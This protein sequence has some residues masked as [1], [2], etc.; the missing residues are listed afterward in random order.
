MSEVQLL[1]NRNFHSGL[2]DWS[3][4][5]SVTIEAVKEDAFK[6]CIKLGS[7]VG[8]IHQRQRLGG[9]QVVSAVLSTKTSSG[10]SAKVR[11]TFYDDNDVLLKSE[12]VNPVNHAS[13]TDSTIYTQSPVFTSYAVLS[14]EN[15]IDDYNEVYIASAS[16]TIIASDPHSP[17][18]NM[19][20]Y[21]FP[22]WEGDIVYGETVLMYETSEAIT[23]KLLYI[24]TVMI[25]VTD[26]SLTTIYSQ[27]TDY[28]IIGNTITLTANSRIPYKC[29]ADFPSTPE[30]NYYNT[31]SSHIVVTYKHKAKWSGPCIG[32][33]GFNMPNTMEKLLN[34]SAIKIVAYGD[35]ITRGSDVS[36]YNGVAPYMPQWDAFFVNILKKRY[37]YD[38]ICLTNAALPGANSSWGAIEID[39]YVTPLDPDLVIIAFG[40]NDFW[41]AT[42]DTFKNN[43]ESMITRIKVK[44]NETEILLISSMMFDRDYTNDGN[45]DVYYKNI[46]SYLLALQSLTTTGVQLHDMTS[47]S[48]YLYAQKKAKDFMPNPLH[49]YDY[50]ARWYGLGLAALLDNRPPLL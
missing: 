31:L 2:T 22:L 18:V 5:G 7:G 43:I 13:Y 48:E 37:G 20:E 14:V 11:L 44:N 21:E 40:M 17:T 9:N 46:K 25:S 6:S 4:Y 36:S 24:P 34:K 12:S 10:T 50:L 41:R 27:E 32:Y 19:D 3:F 38:R 35:S 28:T 29:G 39:T 23:G 26:T 33:K 47:I 15:R 1:N 8:G 16:L 30:L 49:P 45:G 42:G